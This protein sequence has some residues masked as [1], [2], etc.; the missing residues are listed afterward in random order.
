MST[1]AHLLEFSRNQGGRDASRAT[2]ENVRDNQYKENFRDNLRQC[3]I[4]L[5]VSN[6]DG[7]VANRN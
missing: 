1:R 5:V 6:I 4:I 3:Q 7:D 2:T